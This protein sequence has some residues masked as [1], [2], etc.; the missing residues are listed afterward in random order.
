MKDMEKLTH[1]FD[2]LQNNFTSDAKE[3]RRK[4]LVILAEIFDESER[5]ISRRLEHYVY[6]YNIEHAECKCYEDGFGITMCDK[7]IAEEGL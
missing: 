5:T 2:K 3:V 1:E 7:C 4:G 6:R